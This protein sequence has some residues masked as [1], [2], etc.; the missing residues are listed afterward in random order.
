ME[1]IDTILHAALL[2]LVASWCITIA[3]CVVGFTLECL[4]YD[5]KIEK[6]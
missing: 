4:G 6:R 2:T 5:L 3:W 1:V